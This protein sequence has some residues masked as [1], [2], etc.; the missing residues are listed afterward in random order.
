MFAYSEQG[1]IALRGNAAQVALA[2]WLF[3]ELNAPAPPTANP[4][5]YAYSLPSGT[6]DAVRVFRL[7]HAGTRQD[8]QAILNAIRTTTNLQRGFACNSQKA[9]ALRGTDAQIAAAGRIVQ[10]L[11]KP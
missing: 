8:V 7:A 1:S 4:A 5:A 6:T 10:E 3:H 11:D 2:E 9:L